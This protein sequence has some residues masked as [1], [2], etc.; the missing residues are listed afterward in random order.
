MSLDSTSQK[1]PK[2]ET[3]HASS[4]RLA[5]L[6]WLRGAAAVIMLQGHVFHSFTDKP[7]RQSSVYVLSQFIGGLPPA[8]FLFLTGVTLAFLMD[9]AQRKE[10]AP[11]RRFWISLRR[12]GYLF[13]LAFAFRFQLW[14]FGQPSSPWTDLLKVDILNAMGLAIAML[15]VMSVFTTRDR[16][17]LCAALG[18]AIAVVSPWVSSLDWSLVPRPLAVYFV[19]DYNFFGFFPWAAF[20]AFGVSTGSLLR[21]ISKDSIERLMQWSAI[22]GLTL[23]ALA[24]YFADLPY[25]IYTKSDF[26]LDS[27]ALVFIKT[28]I[29]LVMLSFAYVWTRYAVGS[30]KWS[31]VAQFGTTSLLVYWVHIELVYGR[32][33]W[34][35]KENLSVNQAMLAAFA[36]IPLMLGLSVVRTHWSRIAVWFGPPPT[37]LEPAPIPVRADDSG[38]RR[39]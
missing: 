34:A 36:I 21:T 8:L 16:V 35:W 38:P 39:R 14:L 17:R 33:F 5:Y 26:W 12:A 29:I 24:R 25:S 28:G 23:I 4:R 7:G 30:H 37:P 9:S 20:L 15:S 11:M 2:A 1:H 10:I 6:D 32:W 27:P 19:P 18:A 3:V 22:G 13:A 31:W